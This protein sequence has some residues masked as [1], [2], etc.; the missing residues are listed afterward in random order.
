MRLKNEKNPYVYKL[1]APVCLPTVSFIPFFVFGF[2]VTFGDEVTKI[3]KYHLN[4]K[5][6]HTTSLITKI[7]DWAKYYNRL[8]FKKCMSD[9]FGKRTV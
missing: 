5:E 8:L 2:L 9:H 6:N 7:C 1:F 4:W 3:L